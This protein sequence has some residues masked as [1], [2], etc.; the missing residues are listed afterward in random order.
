MFAD[1]AADFPIGE[2][3]A[4]NVH[5]DPAGQKG[6]ALVGGERH[7]ACDGRF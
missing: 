6:G 4:V 7:L 5:I 2:G 1:L 3:L